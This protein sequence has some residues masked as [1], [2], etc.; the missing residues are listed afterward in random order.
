[1]YEPAGAPLHL[2]Y[3]AK[4]WYIKTYN[5]PIVQWSAE[6]AA[7]HDNW[8]GL[9]MHVEV[10]FTLPVVLYAV[11]RFGIHHKGT[12]GADE[13]LF[14]VYA[15]EVAFTTLVCIH[16]VFY[17]DSA[18]YSAELKKTFL[19]QFYGPWFVI[20]KCTSHPESRREVRV[21]TQ[22]NSK[23]LSE[24]STWPP[25]FSV[26]SGRPTLSWKAKSRSKG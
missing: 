23:H 20:R 24:P 13:L 8:M 4:E 11:Y 14:L 12:S 21:L 10:V 15:L 5:D 17:W 22:A 2:I 7:G 25:G 19:V 9:F 16:D 18:V 6:T 1:M 26:A 3:A